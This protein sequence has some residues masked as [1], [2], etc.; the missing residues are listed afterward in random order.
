MNTAYFA[1]DL[2]LGHKRIIEFGRDFPDIETHNKTI[3]KAINDTVRPEDKLY[4]LGDL[5]FNSEFWRLSA[6]HCQNIII[7]LGN[8]D[9]PSKVSLIQE[10]LPQAKLAGCLIEKWKGFGDV[11]ISHMPV[12]TSQLEY[13]ALLNVHGHMHSFVINDSR[14][15]NVSMEQLENWK[16]I[17]KEK[18]ISQT[19]KIN[20]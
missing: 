4:L 19:R 16:P 13:R 18:I 14:Y 3:I 5:A 7:V 15:F 17:S 10:A 1:S 12:H 2:H 20:V 6:L 8:H 9:Y 11:I